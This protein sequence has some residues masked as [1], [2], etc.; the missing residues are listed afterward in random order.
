MMLVGLGLL[1]VAGLVAWAITCFHFD[2]GYTMVPNWE[3]YIMREKA[4]GHEISDVQRSPARLLQEL[5]E[6]R[7]CRGED[8]DEERNN[9]ESE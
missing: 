2:T 7:E 5:E 3:L 6:E 8:R 4:K 1:L 9:E